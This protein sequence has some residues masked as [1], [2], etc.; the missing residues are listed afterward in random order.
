MTKT[1][2]DLPPEIKTAN[3]NVM[4]N[5]NQNGFSLIE[6]LLVVTIIGIIAAI[7]IPNLK[8]A[9]YAAENASMF[10]TMRTLAS[11]QIGFYTNNGRYATL[12]EIS[13]AYPGKFGTLNGNNLKRGS[14]NL[15]MA[16]TDPKD[17]SLKSNFL[18][19][20]TKTL[21]VSDSYYQLSISAD[22][23]IKQIPAP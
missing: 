5:T 11:T 20:A 16:V 19:T 4:K 15:D 2:T 13:A 23:Q 9:K 22:G 8:K 12:S 17:S 7:G 10:A 3:K 1:V 21:D 6:L 14:F 18:V